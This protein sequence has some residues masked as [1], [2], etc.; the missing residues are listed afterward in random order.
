MTE[1]KMIP[2]NKDPLEIIYDLLYQ[3]EVEQ[4]QKALD[5]NKEQRHKDFVKGWQATLCKCGHDKIKCKV[6]EVKCNEN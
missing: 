2:K 1:T 5:E 6:K 4:W 3:P